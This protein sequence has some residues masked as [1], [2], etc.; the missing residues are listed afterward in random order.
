[1]FP[2]PGVRTAPPTLRAAA[3][4]VGA[5]ASFTAMAIAARAVSFELDT[6]EIMMYRSFVGAIVVC[7]VANAAGTL[8]QI[9]RR[10]F[11]LQL[12]RNVAHFIGQN[13]WFLAIML[14]PLAQVFALEFTTPLWALLMAPFVLG[15]K[16]TRGR[17]LA[18]VAGFAGILIVARPTPDTIG[19]G[20]IAAACAA[21]GFAG[22]AVLTRKLTRTETLTCILFYMT[23]LQLIFGIVCAGYD[24]DIAIPSIAS[25]PWLIMIAIGGLFAHFCLTTAL[26]IAPA[27][28]VMP[29]DF[30]RLPM[31]AVVGIV[32]YNEPVDGFVFIGAIMIFAANYVNLLSETRMARK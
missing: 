8:H 7:V 2:N 11:G 5:V 10:Q 25:L 21:I 16:L 1:M 9:S 32:F 18:A 19:L 30:V 15:E 24:G 3:W 12:M 22:S 6:F 27:A 17:V 4:M 26:S 31:I 20:L 28:V 13:L 14:I 23:I 29:V